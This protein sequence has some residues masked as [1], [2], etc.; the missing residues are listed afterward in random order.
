[1]LKYLKCNKAFWLKYPIYNKTLML[2]IL[3]KW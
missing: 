3:A 1:M 2:N